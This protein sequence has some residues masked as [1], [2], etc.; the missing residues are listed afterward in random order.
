L[1]STNSELVN[2]DNASIIKTD[3]EEGQKVNRYDIKAVSMNSL[4]KLLKRKGL[5]TGEE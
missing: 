3:S 5:N 4:K 1:R 2:S